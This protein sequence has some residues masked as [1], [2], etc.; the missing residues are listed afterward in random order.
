MLSKY[1]RSTIIV[2][3]Q[4]IL[5]VGLVLILA[6]HLLQSQNGFNQAQHFFIIHK[7]GFLITHISLYI[8][9]FWLWPRII[10]IYI[11]QINNESTPEQIQSALKAKW[12]L[13]ITMAFFELMV[14]WR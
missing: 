8:A 12:Y 13:L 10:Y 6:P 3:I 14:W 2:L 5:P 4:V 9:L 7:I 1:V 11:K